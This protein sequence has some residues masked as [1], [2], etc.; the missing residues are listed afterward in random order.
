MS[1]EMKSPPRLA[2]Q[3]FR[4]YCRPDRLEELEGDLEEMYTQR[5][6]RGDPQWKANAYFWWN[7]IR[8]FKQYAMSK[9]K[10]SS[11]MS[12]L[13]KSYFKLALR[14][15]W[16]N[17]GAVSINVLGL[18]LALSMCVF[19]YIIHAYNFEF[20]SFYPET[21]GIYRVHAITEQN[22]EGV[23]NEF[24]PVALDF[25]LRESILLALFR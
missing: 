4:W 12:S 9:P 17:K 22:G 18:G 19:V 11:N 2:L 25:E 20:D 7:V 13:F 3:F 5:L 10:T 16:K 1:R 21:E 8:C 24:S 15:S 6:D 23:R 14:H